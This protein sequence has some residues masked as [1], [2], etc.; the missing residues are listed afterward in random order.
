M[1]D[2]ILTHHIGSF[3]DFY[4]CDPKLWVAKMQPV[5]HMCSLGHIQNMKSAWIPDETQASNTNCLREAMS[6][7]F[8]ASDGAGPRKIHHPPLPSS[9]FLKPET[10][11]SS[12]S[13][14]LIEYLEIHKKSSAHTLP[15]ATPKLILSALAL[16]PSSLYSSPVLF[17]FISLPHTSPYPIPQKEK[18]DILARPH[19]LHFCWGL[20]PKK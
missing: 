12:F 4:K 11:F 17:S 3:T 20:I 5:D 16:V 6:K 18:L 14:P 7:R 13:L 15:F 10:Q 1:L 9:Q 8:W 19:W 2:F